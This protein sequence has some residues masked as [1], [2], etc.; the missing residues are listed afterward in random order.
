MAGPPSPTLGAPRPATV[1]TT[2]LADH[3]ICPRPSEV[4]GGVAVGD[5][6]RGVAVGGGVA[7]GDG[8]GGVRVGGGV[9]VG[10][11]VAGDERA[12][13]VAVGPVSVEATDGVGPTSNVCC[14]GADRSSTALSSGAV[15]QATEITAINRSPDTIICERITI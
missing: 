7:V 5:G 11:G 1:V 4:G 15:E 8:I 6:A 2:A 3:G 14:V 13:G 10:K 12:S 9:V